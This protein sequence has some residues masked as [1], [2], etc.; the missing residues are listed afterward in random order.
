MPDYVIQ[1][2]YGNQIEL[3]QEQYNNLPSEIAQKLFDTN[4]FSVTDNTNINANLFVIGHCDQ[5][6]IED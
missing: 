4:Q 1:D 2:K 3:D 6:Y 5:F